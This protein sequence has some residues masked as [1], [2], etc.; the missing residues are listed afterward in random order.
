MRAHGSSES[1]AKRLTPPASPTTAPRHRKHALDGMSDPASL[2]TGG[3][4]PRRVTMRG[5]LGRMAC[6]AFPTYVGGPGVYRAYECW[7]GCSRLIGGGTW[8]GHGHG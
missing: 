8:L 7:S 1:T 4:E 3:P 6:P 2:G 5:L